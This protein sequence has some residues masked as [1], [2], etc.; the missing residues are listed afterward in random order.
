MDKVPGDGKNDSIESNQTTFCD[1]AN[2][3]QEFQFASK[4]R[5]FRSFGYKK[6]EDIVSTCSAYNA[7]II[8]PKNKTELDELYEVYKLVLGL[9]TLLS[10][11]FIFKD[12]A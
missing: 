12:V 3:W 8:T 4:K 6:G 2:G 1:S 9:V 10:L 11:S 7:T 5:C